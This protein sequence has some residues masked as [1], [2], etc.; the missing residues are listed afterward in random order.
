MA[1]DDHEHINQFMA[2]EEIRSVLQQAEI[3]CSTWQ[4]QRHVMHYADV[5]AILQSLKRIGASEIT[6]QRHQGLFTKQKLVGLQNAYERYRLPS[7][8]LP[9]TYNVCY[10]VLHR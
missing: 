6:G 5:N 2:E 1:V 7:G 9:V 3:Q 8:L 4:V 10:G